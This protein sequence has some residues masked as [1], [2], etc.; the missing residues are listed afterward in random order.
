M[1]RGYFE[2]VI[3]IS[4]LRAALVDGENWVIFDPSGRVLHDD[5]P[6]AA[7]P[8]TLVVAP[9]TDAVKR[10]ADGKVVG[11]MDRSGLWRVHALL[12]NRIVLDKLGSGTFEA[13][14]LIDAV[15]ATGISWQA[16]PRRAVG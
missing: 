8:A 14:D 4:T 15:A 12:L 10:V 11:S 5:V 3:D 13:R 6:R 7:G 2:P 1:G 9:L 16:V